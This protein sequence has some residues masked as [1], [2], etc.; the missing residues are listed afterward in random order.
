MP[1]TVPDRPDEPCGILFDKDGTL[2]DF[3]RTWGR[4][5]E[6]MLARLAPDEAARQAMARA[7][8][9]LP[10]ERRFVAGSAVVAGTNSDIARLWAAHRPD[11]GAAA[12]ERLLDESV[13]AVSADPAFLFPA[14]ADL[15]GLLGRLGAMGFRLGV[16]T[17]DT[18]AGARAQLAMAGVA[19]AFVFIAGYDSGHGLK[20][21]PGMA[22]AFAHA[23]GLEPGRMVAVGDSRHDLEAGRA[24]GAGLVI[25]VLTGPAG[26]ADLAPFADHVVASIAGL[27]RL[28]RRWRA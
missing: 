21:G 15:P 10:D 26:R 3:H 23:A 12:I 20:P 19:E 22:R 18:E 11:L 27:P 8:G 25:G 24:A 5:T 9:Y 13:L 4:F 14:V 28:L 7:V 16:A 17:H 2:F 6:A 1:E